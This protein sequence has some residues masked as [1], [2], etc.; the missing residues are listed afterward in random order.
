MIV[1]KGKPEE[2]IPELVKKYG[3]ECVFTNTSYGT[4][5]KKRDELV[6]EKIHFF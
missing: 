1:L 5:G 2:I 6:A 3:I 4:Y